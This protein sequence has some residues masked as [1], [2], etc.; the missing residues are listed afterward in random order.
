MTLA[1]VLA[2][3]PALLGCSSGPTEEQ[4]LPEEDLTFPGATVVERRFDEEHHGTK[5]DGGSVDTPA[6]IWALYRAAPGTPFADVKS[7]YRQKLEPNGWQVI[8]PLPGREPDRVRP[9]HRR[10]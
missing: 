2:V 4:M 6:R 5:I 7:W 8:Q 9:H 10:P 3:A 1:L